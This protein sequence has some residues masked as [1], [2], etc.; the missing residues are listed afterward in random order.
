MP[1]VRKLDGETKQ[2]LRERAAAHGLSMK[3]EARR[4]LTESVRG[5]HQRKKPKVEDL[6]ALGIRPRADF[7]QKAE[8]DALWAC[9][10]E[11]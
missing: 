5:Q 10:G 4:I 7:D 1:T 6:L 3:E 9:I 11:Q 8:F 2:A